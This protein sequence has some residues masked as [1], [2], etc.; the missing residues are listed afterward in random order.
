MKFLTRDET[1]A[2]PVTWATAVTMLSSYTPGH[3]GI[4]S[5]SLD[6]IF[7]R[8]EV[9]NYNKCWRYLVSVLQ[10]CSPSIIVLNIPGILSLHKTWESVSRH[11][12]NNLPGFWP[13]LYWIYRPSWEEWTSYQVFLSMNTE[14]LSFYDL[15]FC[16]SE[17]YSFSHTDLVHIL[18]DLYQIVHFLGC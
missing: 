16:S 15:W 12:Q 10:L 17:V 9:F 3:Q 13:A 14:S 8:T 18:L 6:I 11:P 4:P 2:T 5:H 7:C 1:Q